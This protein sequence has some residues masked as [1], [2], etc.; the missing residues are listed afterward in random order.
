[1]SRPCPGGCGRQVRANTYACRPDWL[2]LPYRLRQLINDTFHQ[3]L[4]GQPGAIQRHQA[5]MDEGAR[6]LKANPQ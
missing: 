1:M 2:R 6:W 3:R 5:A 4:A